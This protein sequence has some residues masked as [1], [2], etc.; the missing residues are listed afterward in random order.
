MRISSIESGASSANAFAFASAAAG[1][2]F[3]STN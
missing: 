1:S 2:R 3:D